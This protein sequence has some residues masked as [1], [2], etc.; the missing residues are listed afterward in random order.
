MSKLNTHRNIPHTKGPRIVLDE[1][2]LQTNALKSL[3]PR[4]RELVDMLEYARPSW[5]STEE[6]FIAEYIDSLPGM[7]RDTF[8]NRYVTIGR[9]APTIA[10]SSH[11]DTV[12]W[13]EGKQA[14]ELDKDN[15]L[16]LDW[17]S[18][19][20]CLGADCTAG[21]W[22]MRRMILAGKP[23]L[24][25]FHRDEENGGN[26][27]TW[28]AENKPEL[29]QGIKAMIALDR[30]GYTS[31]ITEQSTGVTASTKFAWSLADQLGTRWQ[32]DDTGLFT[33]S[34]FYAHLI[35]ECTNISVGYFSQHST[36]ETLDPVFLDQLL[37]AL[38]ALDY[39]K[40]EIAREPEA[41]YSGS[42]YS[43]YRDRDYRYPSPTLSG[44]YEP[45][46]PNADHELVALVR[47]NP[48]AVAHLLR[49]WDITEGEIYEAIDDYGY[50]LE[51]LANR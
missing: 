32:P 4:L 40:L 10:W 44:G 16:A 43:R 46:E 3:K 26:G 18:E 13:D 11:T 36:S 48:E 31:V 19:A 27:S 20:S 8:G 17:N 49:Q 41:A 30:K 15:M 5:S 28:I 23:G 35:P 25:I 42:R 37:M 22:L 29:V 34:A 45:W 6:A 33:D 21:V 39:E 50:E 51:R 2:T 24:Y 9:S 1:A 14:I 7:Q 38:I 47:A 12:H